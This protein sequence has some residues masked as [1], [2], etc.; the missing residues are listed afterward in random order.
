MFT[1]EPHLM[2]YIQIFRESLWPNGQLKPPGAPRTAE[3]RLHTRDDANR[4]LSSLI[5]GMSFLLRILF[6]VLKL[7]F[8]DL[9]ANMIGRSNARRGARRIFAVLQNRRLNQH[10]IYTIVDEVNIL[11]PGHRRCMYPD[12]TVVGFRCA[13]PR[14]HRM[15]Y[16]FR[17]VYP[18][19][20]TS[21]SIV[22]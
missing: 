3:E 11:S 18:F 16:L 10:L 14:D 20:L 12:V 4:K 17:I 1:D 15:R 9:A 13:I 21:S 19:E 7:F 2:S 5:P 6:F 22:T 8:K